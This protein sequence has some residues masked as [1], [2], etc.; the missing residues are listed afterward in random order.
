MKY[1]LT[2]I[3][4]MFVRIYLKFYVS[5][6]LY[7]TYFKFTVFLRAHIANQ[8]FSCA[9]FQAR[10]ALWGKLIVRPDGRLERTAFT[11]SECLIIP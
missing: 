5:L 7:K 11:R 2:L 8:C 6:F 9:V 10:Q 3:Y 4:L 1:I